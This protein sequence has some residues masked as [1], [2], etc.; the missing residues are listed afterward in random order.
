MS[1]VVPK[2]RY[3]GSIFSLGSFS[4]RCTR[5]E[6]RYFSS[7]GNA[8]GCQSLSDLMTLSNADILPESVARRCLT[9]RDQLKVIRPGLIPSMDVLESAH[10]EKR[11]VNGRYLCGQARRRGPLAWYVVLLSH[12]LS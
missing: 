2:C 10:G 3:S 12:N 1:V 9:L 11:D 4:R 6:S 5:S 7:L 8:L